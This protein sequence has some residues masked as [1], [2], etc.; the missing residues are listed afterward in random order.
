MNKKLKQTLLTITENNARGF[1][2]L[3][4][5]NK[6]T[7]ITPL[8]GVR[9]FVHLVAAK[10]YLEI[11]KIILQKHPDL[12]D[13]TD[14]NN[15]TPVLWAA[16]SGHVPVVDFLV[17]LGADLTIPTIAPNHDCH[18]FR[19][20]DWAIKGRHYEV[21]NLLI[22]KITGLQN[23]KAILPFVKDGTQALELM[24]QEPSLINIMLQNDRIVHLIKKANCNMTQ[25]SIYWYK[26][27]G[28]RP[29]FFAHID[30]KS[31]TSSIYKPTQKLGAGGYGVVRLFQ[32]KDGQ[33]IAVKSPINNSIVLSKSK[34]S[35]LTD[36]IKR[37]AEFNKQAYPDDISEIFQFGWIRDSQSIY[38]N[39][40]IMPFIKG[41]TANDLLPKVTDPYQLAEIVLQI[42]RELKRIHDAGIIHGD[43]QRRNIMIRC[44]NTKFVVRFID[45]GLSFYVTE[46]SR[47]FFSEAER[48]WMP[49]ELCGKIELIKP[50]P[51]QDV[52]SL[53]F[54]LNRMLSSHSSHK[55][56]M[57]SF[58][59]IESFI[60]NSQNI[61]PTK[62]P[63]LELF[64]QQL[65]CELNASRSSLTL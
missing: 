58:P 17:G 2:Y 62:R 26:A 44:K 16:A 30:K 40:Y 47:N 3:F 18:G 7:L 25:Q 14:T 19:P 49:P 37:E 54:S 65:S 63:S 33:K 34:P 45:F 9:S 11:I 35:Y 51:N 1:I 10:G 50:N 20:I 28:R 41:E 24:V 56:L 8:D 29:S 27:A 23:K 4:A 31:E 13:I 32:S 48:K 5:N 59:S 12:L 6:S 15:Q 21:A 43:V 42:T 22:L 39:R 61:N 64:C 55:Q 46:R 53:G 38:T 57:S 52:Y 60:A 36:S